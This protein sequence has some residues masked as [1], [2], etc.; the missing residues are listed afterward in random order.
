MDPQRFDAL[1][2][3]LVSG[4]SRRLVLTALTGGLLARLP[5]TGGSEEAQ[6]KKKKKKKKKPQSPLVP[7][8]SPSP[9]GP[10]LPTCAGHV[11]GDDGCG[12]RCGVACASPRI[13]QG[14]ACVCPSGQK[15]CHGTCLLTSQC[16]SDDDCAATQ[17]CFSGTCITV[18]GTCAPGAD[19]CVDGLDS[20]ESLC[21]GGDCFCYTTMGFQTRCGGGAVTGCNTC[22]S[23]AQCAAL[24]PEIP[25][26]F[27]RQD[28]GEQCPCGGVC[29]AP[30]LD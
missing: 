13:C 16:C 5:L 24:H 21:G 28:T 6:A 8:A 3:A 26:I 23:D 15:D 1:S 14:G 30:C 9:P 7:P 11:C 19:L 25:G 18:Q 22:T 2:R 4:T 29:V 20:F 17:G 12:G 27:C 10:C